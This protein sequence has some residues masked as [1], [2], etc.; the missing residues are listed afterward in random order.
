MLPEYDLPRLEPLAR[1][2][3]L[4]IIKEARP[5]I[6]PL[7]KVIPYNSQTK[8]EDA[9]NEI[10][11][12]NISL[13]NSRGWGINPPLGRPKLPERMPIKLTDRDVWSIHG[14]RVHK[15]KDQPFLQLNEIQIG[16]QIKK[17]RDRPF[18]E[19]VN[20]KKHIPPTPFGKTFSAGGLSQT[21]RI[22]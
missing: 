3:S 20:S 5:T 4:A 12:F 1:T 18:I 9:F 8:E 6:G 17:P 2:Q 11:K 14:D 16:A 22:K 10:D 15:P 21:H 13:K 19:R 7:N